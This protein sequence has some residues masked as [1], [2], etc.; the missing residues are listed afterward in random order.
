MAKQLLDGAVVEGRTF[1]IYYKRMLFNNFKMDNCTKTLVIFS[2][3][4][5]KKVRTLGFKYYTIS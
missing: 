2:F 1:Y 3:I 5:R 4:I